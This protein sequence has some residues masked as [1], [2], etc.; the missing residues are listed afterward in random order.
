LIY[1][2]E[3]KYFFPKAIRERAEEPRRHAAV[4]RS[5]STNRADWLWAA[6]EPELKNFKASEMGLLND[7]IVAKLR[8]YRFTTEL[9][10]IKREQERVRPG[11]RS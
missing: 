5:G 3:I 2:F 7:Y 10:L 1:V 8:E 6:I 11:R 4:L 9:E